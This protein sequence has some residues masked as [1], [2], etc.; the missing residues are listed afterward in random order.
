MDDFILPDDDIPVPDDTSNITSITNDTFVQDNVDGIDEYAFRSLSDSQKT[1]LAILPIPSAILSIFG[2]S[3]IIYMAYISRKSKPWTP[4]NRLLVAM[5]VYDIITSMALGAASFL[6]PMETS[7][8]ALAF[9]NDSTC[10]LIGFFN[11]VRKLVQLG[12]F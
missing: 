3:V 10:S 9:G 1:I 4:Y 2:S 8:K 7:K 11:Q 12:W 6:N 5:S